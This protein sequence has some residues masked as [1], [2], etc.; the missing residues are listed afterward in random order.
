MAEDKTKEIPSDQDFIIS[1]KQ[2]VE[3]QTRIVVDFSASWCG[4]C[5]NIAPVFKTLSGKYPNIEVL[6]TTKI[7]HSSL[8][9]V[10]SGR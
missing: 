5:K 6:S 8:I 3:T 1:L 9:S 2:A 10:S 4:P 7:F